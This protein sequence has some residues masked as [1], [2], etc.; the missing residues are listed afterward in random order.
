MK[1]IVLLLSALLML[2]GCAEY[3]QITVDEVTVGSFR[4]TGTSSASIVLNA[5]VNN[6]TRHTISIE[7]VDAILMR[8]GKDFIKFSL[9]GR[10]S[11]APDTVSTV[12]I[13]VKASAL[14][15]ISIITA[16]LNLKS[17][18]L[19]DLMVNGKIVLVT[20]GG[21]RKTMRLKNVPLSDIVDRLK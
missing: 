20:D 15:P 21:A 18:K 5:T 6:P 10:P 11:A 17:W 3:R 19:E 9:D 7:T 1:R 14:D 4:F 13:P 12:S 2:A 16:G 8:E